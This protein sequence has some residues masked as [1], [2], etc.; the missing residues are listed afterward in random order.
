[1][2]TS[3]THEFRTPLNGSLSAIE[4]LEDHVS[5]EGK[6]YLRMAR[7]SNNLLA[8]LMEDILDMAKLEQGVV[9]LNKSPFAFSEL[10][11]TLEDLFS[12]QTKQKGIYLEIDIDDHTRK[13]TVNSDKKR[14]MQILHNLTSNALKFTT[15]GGITIGV[16]SLP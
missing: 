12:L 3:T 7:T 4:L 6:Q 10:A 9:T 15:R 2:L 8:N 1:M 13:Q 11:D 14:I 16:R 5:A